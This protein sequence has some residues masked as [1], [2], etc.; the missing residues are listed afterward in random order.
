[1]INPQLFYDISGKD[2]FNQPIFKDLSSLLDKS[3]LPFSLYCNFFEVYYNLFIKHLPENTE[4]NTIISYFKTADKFGK[5]EVNTLGTF[6]YDGK[7]LHKLYYPDFN[8][9]KGIYPNFITLN[10]NN[11]AMYNILIK[12]SLIE[13]LLYIWSGDYFKFM[14]INISTIQ[15]SNFEN[16]IEIIIYDNNVLYKFIFEKDYLDKILLLDYSDLLD[17]Y[18]LT[19][20]ELFLYESLLDRNFHINLYLVQYKIFC[21]I[22]VKYLFKLKNNNNI[23]L[24]FR[25]KIKTENNILVYSFYFIPTY[26]F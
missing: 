1:M 14:K 11:I 23:L 8:T 18:K 9:R 2:E 19:L 24:K 13:T 10:D 20:H 12:Y 21:F 6:A 7:R 15:L 25:D 26:Y 3:L 17:R 4:P 16:N 22:L 5:N